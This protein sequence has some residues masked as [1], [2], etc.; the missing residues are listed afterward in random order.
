M[1]RCKRRVCKRTTLFEQPNI[2]NR[3]SRKERHVCLKITYEVNKGAYK[4]R[5]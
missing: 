1:R 5:K 3:P 2:Y 4:E